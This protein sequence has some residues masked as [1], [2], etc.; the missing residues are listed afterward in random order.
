[1]ISLWRIFWLETVA[2][3]RGWTAWMLLAAAIGWLLALPRLLTGDGT[4]EGARELYVR[5]GLGGVFAL[6]VVSLLAAA[7]GA[8]A[9]EREERRLQLSLVRPVSAFAVAWGRFLALAALGALV[10]AAA[11]ALVLAAAWT[12]R[13]CSHVLRPLMESPREEAARMYDA[14]M[15]APDTPPE[16][17]KAKKS[18]V[19]RLLEQRAKDNYQSVQTN[20]TASWRFPGFHARRLAS[21]QAAPSVRFRFSGDFDMRDDVRGEIAADGL[22]GGVSNI[23][24]TAVTVP[25]SAC[26][27]EGERDVLSFTNRG[28]G[29]VMLRPRRDVELLF[30]AD[31]FGWNLLR[32]LLVMASVLAAVVAFGVFLG[33]G[34]SRPVAL[35]TA[36]VLLMVSEM[37]PSVVD[38]YPD[39]L[40]TDRIDRVGLAVARAVGKGLRSVSAMSPLGSLAVGDCVE[41]RD[42]AGSV[43]FDFLLV[44]LV[45]SALSAAL[46]RRKPA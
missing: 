28:R 22:C 4:A 29:A 34:L 14:Y 20:E 43:A 8:L 21:P 25:L 30:P 45:L 15:S 37:S 16:V 24:Q 13:P 31:A 42:A 5:Y 44:P 41:A 32:A 40:E 39:Q 35:F 6:L 27:R 19:L 26:G 18:V 2:L 23:T 11:G 33:A 1:M 12:D 46:I 10:L 36:I 9:T 3:W 38:Q 17:R 7:T